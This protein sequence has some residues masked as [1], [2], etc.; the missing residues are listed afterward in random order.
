MYREFEKRKNITINNFRDVRTNILRQFISEGIVVENEDFD[1]YLTK[2][3]VDII[4]FIEQ[5]RQLE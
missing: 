3:N 4:I 2:E 1:N 5:I